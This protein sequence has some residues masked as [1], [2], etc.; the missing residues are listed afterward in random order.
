MESENVIG[1]FSEEQA[2]SIS[3][4]SIYQI[5]FWNKDGL[6][7]PSFDAGQRGIPYGRLYSFRDLVSL[8]I[9]DDLRNGK[10]VPLS[11]LREVSDKL[12]HMGDEK[13]IRSTLYVLGRR[14]VFENP[15]TKQREEIVSGQRVFDIPLR[16]VARNTREK[17]R[18]L[19][20]RTAKAGTAEKRRFVS[21][22]RRVFAGTRVPVSGVIDFLRAGY[23]TEA[24][25]REFP[26]LMPEDVT[27]AALEMD[28][29]A[30]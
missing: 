8:Q 18:K 10:K 27:C 7:R 12:A 3:G 17:I 23:S 25:L 6:I 20:D 16:V 15:G 24:I 19:N 26:D 30:A 13:W 21:G 14:V 9:L 4:L 29:Q 1:A 11:H 2:A 22:N 28:N 5:R